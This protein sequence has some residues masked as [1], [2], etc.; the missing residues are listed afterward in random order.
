MTSPYNDTVIFNLVHRDTVLCFVCKSQWPAIINQLFSTRV[1]LS[2]DSQTH[3]PAPGKHSEARWPAVQMGIDASEYWWNS[4]CRYSIAWYC[5]LCRGGND[6]AVFSEWSVNNMPLLVNYDS[7]R[8]GTRCII[9]T[10]NMVFKIS[11]ERLFYVIVV[12]CR[13]WKISVGS[14]EASACGILHQSS[15]VTRLSHSWKFGLSALSAF[16]RHQT[17]MRSGRTA[18][19]IWSGR[20]V[21]RSCLYCR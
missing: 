4:R 20:C 8:I 18:P 21:S 11:S 15:R 9:W 6:S 1:S 17:D 5:A 14:G 3:S 19:R 2:K 16:T 7:W 12:W 13:Y 10:P